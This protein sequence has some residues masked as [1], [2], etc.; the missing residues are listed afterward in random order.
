MSINK[1]MHKELVVFISH[2]FNDFYFNRYEELKDNLLDNQ[3]LVWVYNTDLSNEL[4]SKGIEALHINLS[5]DYLTNTNNKTIYP[6]TIGSDGRD[7]FNP[8]NSEYFQ[9]VY[10]EY[11]LYDYYWFVENDVA[12]NTKDKYNSFKQIFE[13]YKDD[14]ADLIVPTLYSYDNPDLDLI[15]PYES[16]KGS[17]IQKNDL[18]LSFQT[19]T[20]H[21]NK[22]LSIAQK[23][24]EYH[25]L[26]FEFM[27]PTIAK[28]Y[29]L[30][31]KV[32]DFKFVN[33]HPFDESQL[34]L[35]RNYENRI[36]NTSD[37]WNAQHYQ[38]RH[39]G[40]STVIIEYPS[41]TVLHPIKSEN[42]PDML[43]NYERFNE[44]YNDIK[45]WV[46]GG[47]NFSL[48][49]F[50]PRKY[51]NKFD[52]DKPYTRYNIN[53]YNRIF[54][55]Y[56]CWYYVW[57]NSIKSKY[58]ATAHYKRLPKYDWL[59]LD[60]L[61]KGKYQYFY[62]S[63]TRLSGNYEYGDDFAFIEAQAKDFGC[64]PQVIEDT[65]E[66][67]KTQTLVW[68][69]DVIKYTCKKDLVIFATR[70]IFACN[71]ENFNRLMEFIKSYIDF[72]NVKY[73][74]Y[75]IYRWKDHVSST[76]ISWY[77]ENY[78]LFKGNDRKM[79]YEVE[80]DFNRIFD[81]DEGYH[82]KCNCWRVY[83]YIIE[84]LIS[85]WIMTHEHCQ[86]TNWWNT[87]INL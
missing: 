82:N 16:L 22:L 13:F 72:I 40:P 11:P 36:N 57:T 9:Q 8:N 85:V 19:F 39:I 68:V 20:R 6:K 64:P 43:E 37:T 78:D 18:W 25:S 45:I 10:K 53:K 58:I 51:Y 24:V 65:I 49:S 27:Y 79:V 63:E 87:T 67:L 42:K 55:E 3:H 44:K 74:L 61:D 75:N 12:I 30:K 23:A 69:D 71:W 33:P 41:T 80:E 21:S 1:N 28:K 47:K 4:Q 84:M 48:P 7:S 83:S 76:I 52:N 77:K 60:E 31:I 2:V 15:Y 50:L 81:W 70:E 86:D 38:D 59:S 56:T 32:F 29:G 17:G 26:F 5:D 62:L 73:D 35:S 34:T 54:S 14:D 46:C 66:W